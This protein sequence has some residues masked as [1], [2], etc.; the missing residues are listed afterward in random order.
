[1][2]DDAAV[3]TTVQTSAELVE[4]AELHG[5]T[6]A[7]IGQAILLCSELFTFGGGAYLGVKTNRVNV[8]RAQCITPASEEYVVNVKVAMRWPK[9][10]AQKDPEYSFHVFYAQHDR[11][12]KTR[13]L[14]T[15][16]PLQEL[17]P[18]PS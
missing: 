6:V 15:G 9:G 12:W 1:M 14:Y 3:A 7:A 18:M 8:P 13:K 11:C 5:A 16:H 10:I 2:P 17:V 4:N